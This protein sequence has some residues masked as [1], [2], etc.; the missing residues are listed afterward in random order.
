M[1]DPRGTGGG[2]RPSRSHRKRE[3]EERQTLGIRLAELPDSTLDELGLPDELLAAIR[4]IRHMR[5]GGGL[6]RERQRIGTLM[7]KLDPASIEAALRQR[8]ADQRTA[9]RAF[10]RLER[11][12]DGL[13]EGETEVEAELKGLLEAD[14][15]A[16]A[17]RLAHHARQEE[18]HGQPPASA[19]TLFRLLRDRLA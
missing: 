11:L 17:S 15:F 10:H 3:A 13:M 19:R 14:D 18:I 2:D 16:E 9:A 7:R 4:R 1:T 8:E 5:R 6:R 12:R